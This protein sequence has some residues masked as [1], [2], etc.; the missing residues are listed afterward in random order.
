MFDAF[1]FQQV[2]NGLSQGLVYALMAIGFTLIFGVLNVVN[3]A[4]GELYML[5]AFAGLL[6]IQAFAPPLI[7]VLL[8]VVAVGL[9]SGVLLERI[10]FRPLRRFADEASLKSKAIREATLLSSLAISIVVR[11]LVSNLF[12]SNMQ[13]IPQQYL[14]MTPITLGPLTFASGQFVIFGFALAMLLA[15][16]W[17]L[18]YTRSG[19]SV[20]AVASNLTGALHVGIDIQ[21]T[22]VLTFMLGAALGAVS[23]FLVGLYTGNIFPAMGFGAGI[24][25]FVAMVMGGLNSIPGAIIC[26]LILGLSEAIATEYIPQG[27]ADLISYGLLLLTLLFF[28]NGIFGGRR[29]RV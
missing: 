24:K 17:F 15:L 2:V 10:A 6:V 28:P 16:Q 13:T 25:A 5:G 4:H 12:G 29:E 14:L 9:V 21:R 11:E 27:W 8:L 19:L 22:I 3:F 26:A 18:F 1:F 23:G 20:R 7:A